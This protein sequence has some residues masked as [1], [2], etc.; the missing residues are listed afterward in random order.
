MD[1]C[2]QMAIPR[3]IHT[4]VRALVTV[5]D[6][7]E[8]VAGLDAPAA[9]RLVEDVLRV[10]LRVVRPVSLVFS[11]HPLVVQCGWYWKQKAFNLNHIGLKFP[12]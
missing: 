11:L 1:F 2:H 8:A 12:V 9:P 6:V 4:Y 7:V 10:V 3:I 5:C